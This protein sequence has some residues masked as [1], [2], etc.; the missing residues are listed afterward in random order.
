MGRR[1]RHNPRTPEERANIVFNQL[2]KKSL[3]RDTAGGKVFLGKWCQ[4]PLAV[5]G[6]PV[7]VFGL[8]LLVGNLFNLLTY[9][10]TPDWYFGLCL[11]AL[12]LTLLGMYRLNGWNGPE[13]RW[14]PL[15]M[16]R[17]V[18]YRCKRTHSFVEDQISPRVTGWR[19]VGVMPYTELMGLCPDLSMEQLINRLRHGFEVAD[20]LDEW[21]KA[22]AAKNTA[23]REA[24]L[25]AQ[26]QKGE[27]ILLHMS[28]DA[29]VEG[30]CEHHAEPVPT[31]A[32]AEAQL[33]AELRQRAG[34]VSKV[35]A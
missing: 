34:F 33:D 8:F 13:K 14:V 21:D 30:Y 27:D 3:P 15:Q 5:Q 9:P 29:E 24:A 19:R 32:D 25:S 1:R 18:L 4:L 6:I 12:F 10:V 2:I 23:E 20:D 26:A 22:V 28:A 17:G 16:H 35:H 11:V 31:L 7:V